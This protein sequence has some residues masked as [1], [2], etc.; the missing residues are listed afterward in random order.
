MPR[1][2]QTRAALSRRVAT[3]AA[4]FVLAGAGAVAG[5]V[6]AAGEAPPLVDVQ[7]LA[8]NDFHGNLEPPSGSSGEIEDVPAGGVEFLATQLAMLADEVQK[9]NTITVAAGDLIG[10]SPL[11]SAAFHDE[12]TIE[13]LG[14]AGLDLA[15][16]GNH[17]FDEGSDELL[18]IQ[19]GGCHPE[20]GCADPARP[21]EGAGF[22]YLSANAFVTE[23]GEPLLPPYAIEK[24]QGM[25]IGFI[26]MTLE[27]TPDIV[28]QSGIAG[29]EFR[30]E[31]E[32]GNRY[33]AELQE[34]GV[35]AIVVLLHEGGTQAGGG[36]INDCTGLTGPV[37]DIATGFSDAIDVVVSG[38][39]HQAYNCV[40]DDK[41]VT[42]AS[43]FGRL[44]TDIDLQ[45][46]R[47][48]G[49]V[50]TAKAA[51]V[52]VGRDV[53]ADADQTELIGRY[54]TLLGPIAS[55]E[56]GETT[57]A[58]TREA[59][60]SGESALGNLIADAQLAATDDEQGA[61]AA[62]MNP[63][64]VRADLDAGP[65]TYEEAFTVQPF[66]NYLTTLDLTGAQLDCLLEQ[67]FVT[68]RILQ[69]SASV[70]YTVNQAGAPGTAADPCTGT[71]V[72][73]I[74]IGG[75]PVDP[76]A[77]YRITVNSFLADG[78]D[79][80]SVLTQGTNEVV[81]GPDLDAFTAYLT[82]NRPTAPPATDR[83]TLG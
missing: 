57:A 58:I 24:V 13:A 28:T 7:L 51:N 39:T 26:G 65:V 33:A 52:I 81:G 79:G 56:V 19:N 5:A 76:A 73:A 32:T 37:V 59:A 15:S 12:P 50:I 1:S 11:L 31:V 68:E 64:G 83:I 16:V 6:P 14:L 54:R 77:T 47:A 62:F 36:G 60:P 46:D 25:R 74:T 30:D 38:H 18:R 8:L 53:P 82:A 22:Q 23:T 43:S 3:V 4:G 34:Q 2:S 29:L 20:D 44:V 17:E 67:Q 42:S 63:G 10:A 55:E 70:R 75:A 41:I 61:V 40:I 49:D 45:I 27:G 78:G 9:P 21:Y 35:E 72:D 69:P 66:N 71:K 80:F 48:T